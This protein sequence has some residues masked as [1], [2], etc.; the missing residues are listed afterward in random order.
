MVGIS[1]HMTST[2]KCRG[3]HGCSLNEVSVI[4]LTN[5]DGVSAYR[6]G[7]SGQQQGQ[8]SLPASNVGR[9]WTATGGPRASVLRQLLILRCP[10]A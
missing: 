1:R 4:V 7:N 5:T 8:A 3:S 2:A 6:P 9:G 10:H